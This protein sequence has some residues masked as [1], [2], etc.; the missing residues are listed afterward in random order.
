MDQV[1]YIVLVSYEVLL[2]LNTPFFIFLF[3]SDQVYVIGGSNG[4]A[5]NTVECFDPHSHTWTRAPSMSI[6]RRFPAVAVLSGCIYVMGGCDG[7]SKL[8]S[9]E[10]YDPFTFEWIVIQPMAIPRSGASATSIGRHIF[11]IGGH[12]ESK[13]LSSV[14]CYDPLINKWSEITGMGIARDCAGV[15]CY[16]TT[17]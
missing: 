11:V 12:D 16:N 9:V 13:P 5:L 17:N 14:E 4:T 3:T 10:R 7:T 8:S 6:K 2:R 1:L 15:A